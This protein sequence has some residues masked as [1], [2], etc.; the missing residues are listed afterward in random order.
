MVCGCSVYGS[1]VCDSC[2]ITV[3]T[4]VH[5]S[6][7]LWWGADVTHGQR[8][9]QCLLGSCQWHH[10]GVYAFWPDKCC[11]TFTVSHQVLYG[12][13]PCCFLARVPYTMAFLKQLLFFWKDSLSL[14]FCH[15]CCINACFS[16]HLCY[17]TRSSLSAQDHNHYQQRWK[18]TE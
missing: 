18:R 11:M 17:S 14:P 2:V 7:Q 10:S 6:Y 1:K 3:S 15:C 12:L 9:M 8:R 4:C 5:V 16:Q 13:V